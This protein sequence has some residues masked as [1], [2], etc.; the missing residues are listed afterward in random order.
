MEY[1]TTE[2]DFPAAFT[3]LS[4]EL[5]YVPVM[6]T[7]E[8]Q[9]DK[10]IDHPLWSCEDCDTRWRAHERMRCPG[11]ACQ[12][13]DRFVLNEDQT[14]DLLDALVG[15][16]G[17][18]TSWDEQ[19]WDYAMW[20]FRN[21]MRIHVPWYDMNSRQTIQACYE[22]LCARAPHPKIAFAVAFFQDDYTHAP[23][24]EKTFCPEVPYFER[25]AQYDLQ[26][27]SW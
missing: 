27:P 2:P 8:S 11:C 18:V 17:D 6:P 3:Q 12:V 9:A 26:H 20:E 4:I 5:H 10:G 16:D 21:L 15:L 14:S 1:A 25:D 7:E 24:E 23:E 19:S 22:A 13:G